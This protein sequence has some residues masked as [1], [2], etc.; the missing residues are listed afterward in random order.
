MI[1]TSGNDLFRQRLVYS[2]VENGFEPWLGRANWNG[3][4]EVL[5][6]TPEKARGQYRRLRDWLEDN[7]MTI[8]EYAESVMDLELSVEKIDVGKV[9]KNAFDELVKASGVDTDLFQVERGSVWG[10]THNMSASFKFQRRIVPTVR[11]V[12]KIVEELREYAPK[13]FKKANYRLGNKMALISLYDI[14]IGRMGFGGDGTAYTVDLYKDVL[15]DLMGAISTYDLEEIVFVL[16]NDFANYDNVMGATTAG[17]YQEQ[18]VNWKF[19]I[20]E[21][22]NLAVYTIDQLRSIAPVKVIMVSGN[23]DRFSNYFLGKFVEGW[24][25]E[26]EDVDV[27]NLRDYRKYY[28]YGSTAFMFT[29]GNEENKNMIPAIF[30]TE[31]VDVFVGAKHREVHMG[32]YHQRKDYFQT[33]TEEFGIYVRVLP[34]LSSSSDW[35]SMKGFILHNRVGIAHIYDKDKGQIAEFY[36]K[37]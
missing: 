1:N 4:A 33:V 32:H 36:G 29:H 25:R 27:D 21:Q 16:G 26:C 14:Q 12:D 8:E 10:S 6:V 3:T 20:D 24:Y 35:E 37:L 2:L 13:K 19:G 31:G 30:A 22:C 7:D 23:H 18:D 9:E 34:S 28:R 11:Q 5:G 15:A 17:T